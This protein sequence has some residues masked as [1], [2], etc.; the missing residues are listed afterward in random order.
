MKFYAFHFMPYPHLED[1]FKDKYQ[2]DWVSYPNRNYDPVRGHELYNTYIDQLV[3]AAE[4]G[5]DGIT[6]NEHHQ[7]S[8]G[9]MPSPNIVAAMLVQRTMGMPTKIGILGNAI[10]LRQNP[11]R[12]AEEIAMLDVISGGR[13]ISGF[14]RGIGAEY[15]SLG[16]NPAESRDRFREAHDVIVQA[17]SQD[18]PFSFEGDFFNYR[19]VNTWPRPFQ[20]PHPEVWAPSTGSGETVVWAAERAYTYAQVFSPISSVE[21]IFGEYRSASD[22]F[23][24]PDASSRLA[25]APAVY[26]ADSDAQAEDEFWP[27]ADLYFN[28]LFPNPLHRLFPP[29]YMEEQTLE[30]VLSLRG[31]LDKK[32]DF[33]TL[34][35]NYTAIVGSPETVIGMLEDAHD[36]LGFEHLVAYIHLGALSDELVR[37]NIRRMTTDVMPKLRDRK[38][39]KDA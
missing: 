39:K 32:T 5:F 29:N 7:T 38:S 10:S 34:K 25:W 21:K 3:Y 1:G 9:L 31:D 24:V 14:V 37:N 13:M 15:H 6:V 33:N 23:G 11:L 28:N 12:V 36:R 35:S 19:Y 17:W 20:R 4:M 2:S 27:N 18:G 26:V 8:Y 30:R 22:K 16:M